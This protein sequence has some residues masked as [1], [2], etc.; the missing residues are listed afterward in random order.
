MWEENVGEE[1]TG[2]LDTVEHLCPEDYVDHLESVAKITKDI[3]GLY[4]C[5]ASGS[6]A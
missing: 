6:T 4:N 3:F 1:E 5:S 2:D